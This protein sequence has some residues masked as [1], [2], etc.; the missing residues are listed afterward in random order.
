[1]G[2]CKILT[3]TGRS[4][5]ILSPNVAPE[6][7]FIYSDTISLPTPHQEVIKMSQ[8]SHLIRREMIP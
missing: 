1:M 8:K 7:I 3:P 4:K 2:K 5:C 6:T